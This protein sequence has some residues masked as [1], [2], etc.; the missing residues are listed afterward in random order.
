MQVILGKK[1]SITYHACLGKILKA[2][3]LTS[4]RVKKF[5]ANVGTELFRVCLP[6][7]ADLHATILYLW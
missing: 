7:V 4:V 5:C 2:Q 3:V 1:N 6:L